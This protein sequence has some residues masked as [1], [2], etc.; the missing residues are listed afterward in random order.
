LKTQTFTYPGFMSKEAQE[1]FSDKAFR[2]A[3]PNVEGASGTFIKLSTGETHLPSKGETFV[4][5]KNGEIS[6]GSDEGIIEVQTNLKPLIPEMKREYFRY[7]LVDLPD[8]LRKKQYPESVVEVIEWLEKETNA[9]FVQFF[10][11]VTGRP[12]YGEMIARGDS[13]N[14]NFFLM[15][16][17]VMLMK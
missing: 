3:H 4:K 8:E 5:D 6:L 12:G 9:E 11:L 1:F 13:P 7:M 15:R 17:N 2:E 16:R 14:P 10:D